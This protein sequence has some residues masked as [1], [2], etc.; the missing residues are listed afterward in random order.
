[1]LQFM[2]YAEKFRIY[3]TIPE[4]EFLPF[5]RQQKV[6]CVIWTMQTQSTKTI[7]RIFQT[8]YG[9]TPPVRRLILRLVEN[10]NSYGN[11]ENRTGRGR[12]PVTEKTIQSVGSYFGKHTRRSP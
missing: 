8:K 3:T 4:I 2:K 6:K 11:V 9:E 1:M 5:K 12:P 10:F 7:G